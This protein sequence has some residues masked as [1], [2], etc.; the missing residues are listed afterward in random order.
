MSAP[1][2]WIDGRNICTVLRRTLRIPFKSEEGVAVV[3]YALIATFIALANRRWDDGDWAAYRDSSAT[4][5]AS[6]SIAKDERFLCLA[7]G[8]I[9]CQSA[10]DALSA[11]SVSAGIVAKYWSATFCPAS[12]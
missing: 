2:R 9:I 1:A 10:S 12:S 5:A 4:S 6:S 11:T 3:R 7:T 8:A